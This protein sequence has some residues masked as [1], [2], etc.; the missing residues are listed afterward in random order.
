MRTDRTLTGYFISEARKHRS[1]YLL[2]F[3]L[4]PVVALLAAAAPK[5]VQLAI[6]KGMRA[7][8]LA[9]LGKMA[10]IYLGIVVLRILLVPCQIITMQTAGI[11]TLREMRA[12]VVR[13]ICRLGKAVYDRFP[14]GVF[15]ARATSDVEAVGETLATS[16]MSI[17]TDI[18]TIIAILAVLIHM[19][20]R[21]GLVTLLLLPIVAF[22]INW[23]RL[24]LRG[25]HN[26]L[27]TLN[28]RLSAHLNETVAMRHEILN[29]HLSS[30]SIREYREQN[31]QYR[32]TA[33]RAVS[34]DAGTSAA[35]EGLSYVSIGLVLL[36]VSRSWFLSSTISI[37]EVVMYIL[38]LQQ[39]F[40][41]FKQL[42]QRFTSI[43]ATYAALNKIHTALLLP[44]P[45]DDGTE[46]PANHDL[47][48]Q[49]LHFAYEADAE[50]LKG[51]S[52]DVAEGSS[53]AVVGPTGSGKTTLIR[54]LT[55]QYEADRG[56]IALGNTDL[57]S[58]PREA[59][60]QCVVLVPQDPTIFEGTI[61]ENISLGR[62]DVSRERVMDVCRKITAHDFIQ[63]LPAGYDT[64]LTSGGKNLSMGQRQLVALA[65]ALAA[66]SRILVFDESTA[67]IDT[68]TELLIQ[69]ALDFVMTQKTTIIIA[70]R[71]STIRHVDHILV[72]KNGRIAEQGTHQQLLAQEGLY[73]KMY[74][75]QAL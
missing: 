69:E 10:L 42:G 74:A 26:R 35:I 28:G 18:F 45:E 71:L 11:R 51:I 38:Y 75:L 60:K 20:V 48:V 41:P 17:F 52:L 8:D 7:G 58:I 61:A 55:R 72:L 37:G 27:R 13:H 23:F 31:G 22:I 54:L 62:D 36:L 15:V 16:L 14:L 57:A 44:L 29:F 59:L 68:E 5:V 67:N 30:R 63:R 49:D 47:H 24:R 64:P 46:R 25:F 4:M 34:Y 19:N 21:L 33:I 50:I 65:R 3:A 1:A 56:R 2:A 9:A 73:K 6:D 66:D 40:Q 12:T 32:Y 53:L 39:L 43:Q 70:H